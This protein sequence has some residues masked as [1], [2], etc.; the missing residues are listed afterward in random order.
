M[1]VV[2][3]ALAAFGAEASERTEG[4]FTNRV[5]LVCDES[6]YVS[7]S[8]LSTAVRL[9]R[10]HTVRTEH[11][12][13]KGHWRLLDQNRISIGRREFA[14]LPDESLFVSSL[15]NAL[16][17]GI[18]LVEDSKAGR[19]ALKARERRF[20]SV[21]NQRQ[22]AHLYLRDG[23]HIHDACLTLTDVGDQSSIELLVRVLPNR[24]TM[25]GTLGVECTFAHCAAA[26]SRI[27]G[28]TC[29]VYRE[30]W[31]GCLAASAPNSALQP[32]GTAAPASWVLQ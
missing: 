2:L 17:F 13:L 6:I 24:P 21:E 19:R 12:E 16:E 28:K 3:F 8:E 5:F 9:K 32:T 20:K 1:A 11:D 23:S 4:W 22:V 31:D 14:F 27:T 26:L 7:C 10:D 29:G 15:D 30:E 25:E 18:A